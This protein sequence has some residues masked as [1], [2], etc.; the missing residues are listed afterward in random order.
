MSLVPSHHSL[1]QTRPKSLSTSISHSRSRSQ[2]GNITQ[3]VKCLPSLH[4]SLG[5]TPSIVCNPSTWE[6][7]AEVSEVQGQPQLHNKFK[8]Y[9]SLECMR[10][11]GLKKKKKKSRFLAF[12]E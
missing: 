11:P 12:H 6:V 4:E 1:K 5:S 9:Q 10:S 2:A 8:A 7:K 3:T